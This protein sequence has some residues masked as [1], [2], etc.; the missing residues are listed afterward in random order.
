MKIRI[1]ATLL[2]AA[3]FAAGAGEHIYLWPE[4]KMP[5]AQPHQIAASTEDARAKGF[6]A[7]EWRRPYIEWCEPPAKPN[8]CCM[9]LISGGGYNCYCDVGLIRMWNK[10][11]TEQGF[12]CVQ[13]TRARGRTDSEPSAW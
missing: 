10:K 5:N 2:A 12:Q 13:S 3:A 8:G 9:I 1:I 11:F 4:G 7:D 6:K